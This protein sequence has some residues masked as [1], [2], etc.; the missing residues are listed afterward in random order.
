M[1]EWRAEQLEAEGWVLKATHP[2]YPHSIRIYEHPD[3][4][5]KA[6]KI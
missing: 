1:R 5:L 4:G 3:N 2:G 6:V